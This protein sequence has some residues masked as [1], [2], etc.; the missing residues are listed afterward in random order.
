MEPAKSKKNNLISI[1]KSE[2]F[3][4]FENFPYNITAYSQ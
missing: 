1:K 4:S 2:H 3:G